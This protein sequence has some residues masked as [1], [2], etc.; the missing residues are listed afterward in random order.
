VGERARPTG[1]GLVVVTDRRVIG[2]DH[3]SKGD[4]TFAVPGEAVALV[5]LAPAYAGRTKVGEEIRLLDEGGEV[6]GG[7]TALAEF[8]VFK[9]GAE[10]SGWNANP[11]DKDELVE[12]QQRLVGLLPSA[13]AADEEILASEAETATAAGGVAA[14]TSPAGGMRGLA[15]G[16]LLIIL[17]CVAIGYVWIFVATGGDCAVNGLSYECV[18]SGVTSSIFIPWALVAVLFG[19]LAIVA[20]IVRVVRSL[21]RRTGR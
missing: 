2:T 20:G 17:G 7:G 1:I 18:S 15:T 8:Q 4:G 12:V 11:R 14:G 9:K 5:E 6:L 13:E 16:L 3:S 10:P 21:S 19:I